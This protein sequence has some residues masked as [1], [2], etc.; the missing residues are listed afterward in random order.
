MSNVIIKAK[1]LGEAI[2]TSEVYSALEAVKA[3]LNADEQAQKLLNEYNSVCR[4]FA[5][6]LESTSDEG[7]INA[8]NKRVMALDERVN[9]NDI[10]SRLKKAQAEY[11][12][13]MTAVNNVIASHTE[14]EQSSC[15]GGCGGCK[16]CG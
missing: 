13:L 16:G 1:E 3:E 14:K 2:V 5:S 9:A 8:E 7:L 11:N 15:G 12:N 10:L 6:I 4:G